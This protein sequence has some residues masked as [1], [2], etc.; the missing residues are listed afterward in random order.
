MA[1]AIKTNSVAKHEVNRNFH[2]E[3]RKIILTDT[4]ADDKSRDTYE[5]ATMFNAYTQFQNNEMTLEE[6][7]E[8]K[9]TYPK[10]EIFNK[11]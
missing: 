6:Y 11:K 8:W 9:D 10:Q 7:K 1:K 4:S 3:P 5:H 2:Q